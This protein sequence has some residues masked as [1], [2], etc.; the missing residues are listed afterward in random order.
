MVA[1]YNPHNIKFIFNMIPRQLM[2]TYPD[3]IMHR[4]VVGVIDR[5]YPRASTNQEMIVLTKQLAEKVKNNTVVKLPPLWGELAYTSI[6]AICDQYLDQL[7]K[8]CEK[9]N[10]E[11]K[12]VAEK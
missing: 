9:E 11:T 2:L 3:A 12:D 10:N 4:Q 7:Q 8:Y 1:L 5:L 6:R